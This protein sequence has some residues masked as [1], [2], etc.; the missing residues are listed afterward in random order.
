MKAWLKHEGQ[1]LAG[2]AR[3]DKVAMMRS[4]SC[5]RL[6][7]RLERGVQRTVL[8]SGTKV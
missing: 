8:W 3:R 1:A 7:P 2:S 4:N 5:D 6:Y